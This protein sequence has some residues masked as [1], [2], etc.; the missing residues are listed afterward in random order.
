MYWKLWKYN[1]PIFSIFI[2]WDMV[3][4]VL[5]MLKRLTK[6]SPKVANFFPPK[7]AQW[8]ETYAKSIIQFLRFLFFWDMA[9]F[10]LKVLSKLKTLTTAVFD[11]LGTLFRYANQWYL[12]NNWLEGFN[13]KVFGAWGQSPSSI[14][15]FLL[16]FWWIF[17][18]FVSDY[19]KQ[20]NKLSKISYKKKIEKI[21][22]DIFL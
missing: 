2:F 20:K 16:L 8:S 6:I 11:F 19:F 22:D 15:F 7:V 5:K 14:I 13:P 21:G 18:A 1:F 9:D 4:F 12:I 3:V 10:V 17:F